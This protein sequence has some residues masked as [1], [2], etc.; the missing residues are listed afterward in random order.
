MTKLYPVLDKLMADVGKVRSEEIKIGVVGTMRKVFQEEFGKGRFAKL[1]DKLGKDSRA[2]IITPEAVGVPNGIIYAGELNQIQDT[3]NHF[4][5]EKIDGLIIIPNNRKMTFQSTPPCP[6][7][8][9]TFCSTRRKAS[10]AAAPARATTVR[11][12]RSLAIRA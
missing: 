6:V 9:A 11:W 1:L 8:K 3:V 10:T 4:L 12:M 2:N 7:P 5:G